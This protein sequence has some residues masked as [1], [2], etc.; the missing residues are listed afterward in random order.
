M[1]VLIRMRGVPPLISDMT[2]NYR[3]AAVEAREDLGLVVYHSTRVLKA[4]LDAPFSPEGLK[5]ALGHLAVRAWEA[6]GDLPPPTYH[7]GDP[8]LRAQ[9]PYLLASPP[10]EGEAG[11]LSLPPEER[12]ERLATVL[13]WATGAVAEVGQVGR[14]R[15]DPWR[16]LPWGK[17]WGVLKELAPLLAFPRPG[18]TSLRAPEGLRPTRVAA[19]AGYLAHYRAPRLKVEL[20][21]PREELLREVRTLEGFF[22][23]DTHPSTFRILPGRELLLR[24]LGKEEAKV[25]IR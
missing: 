6:L 10:P 19:L 22:R 25:W 18:E 8:E 20:A 1:E 23:R 9:A 13:L 4:S 14:T 5:G 2:V 11:W 12:R 21:G 24:V 15:P 7:L 16:D 17:R 3:P